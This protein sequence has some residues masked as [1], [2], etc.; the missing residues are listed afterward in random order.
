MIRILDCNSVDRAE[1]FQRGN[2]SDTKAVEEAVAA[3]L[4]DVRTRGDAAV[5]EYTARF[6]GAQLSALAVT[7]AEI[8]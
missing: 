7:E 3:I 5:L 1:I 4:A 6:D 8:E 2:L